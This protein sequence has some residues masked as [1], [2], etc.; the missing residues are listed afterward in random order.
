MEKDRLTRY[1]FIGIILI[2]L[3]FT[4]IML[5]PFLTYMTI[6][7]ILTY[8]TYPVYKKI[9]S[10]IKR[11]ELASAL[12][13]LIIL[14]ILI[15]PSILIIQTLIVEA[16]NT[17]DLVQKVSSED[18]T[19]FFEGFGIREEAVDSFTIEFL[20]KFGNFIVNSASELIG[21]LPEKI[22]GIFVLF[23]VMYYGF[24]EGKELY[25]SLEKHLPIKSHHKNKLLKK[26]H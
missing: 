1:F 4:F 22:L 18:M 13:I 2:L 3:Y 12:M 9:N 10:K 6:G 25:I 26:I 5:K 17:M 20:K 19:G 11:K 23:F 14:L 24:K 7:I 21:S 16:T 15:I 8:I